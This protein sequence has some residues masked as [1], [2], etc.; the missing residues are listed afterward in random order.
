MENF[1]V[2]EVKVEIGDNLKSVMKDMVAYQNRHGASAG[3][4]SLDVAEIVKGALGKEKFANNLRS[5]FF[6]ELNDDP[7][8]DEESTAK[9]MKAFENALRMVGT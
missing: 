5:K 3:L 9:A 1:D 7:T 6:E 2:K 8:I 4:I